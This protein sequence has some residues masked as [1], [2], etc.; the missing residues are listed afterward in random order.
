MIRQRMSAPL[1]AR[2]A[3]RRLPAWRVGLLLVVASALLG[4]ACLGGGDD[5][6]EVTVNGTPLTTATA[7]ATDTPST[8]EPTATIATVE[9][10]PQTSNL[11]PD[12]LEGFTMPIAGACLPSRDAVLPN[13]PR[14]YRNGVHEGVDFYGGDVCIAITRGQDVIAM[15]EGI[16]IRADHD[17]TDITAQQVTDLAAKTAEQGF[18]DP[19]TLDIYRGRQVWIDHGNGIVT[20]Y[21]HLEGVADTIDVGVRVQAGA[22][23][24]YIGESGTPESITDPGTEVHLHAEVRVGDSFLG[25][26]LGPAEV[27]EDYSQLFAQSGG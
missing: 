7:A 8:P 9:P 18:T 21:A 3:R 20:R 16:V 12:A 17:Y 24:A 4:V 15:F 19:E 14:V 2:M 10:P 13:A 26:G 23:I 25:D 22:V 1:T 11:D 5:D 6:P 27:R